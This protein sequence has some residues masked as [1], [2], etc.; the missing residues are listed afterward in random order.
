[1]NPQLIYIP[2][3]SI[4]TLLFILGQIQVS[5]YKHKTKKLT[6]LVDKEIYENVYP[7]FRKKYIEWTGPCNKCGTKTQIIE[8][9]R[10][11][12]ERE[13]DYSP[14][15]DHD[16]VYE[17]KISITKIQRSCPKCGENYC[18]LNPTA[19]RY[20]ITDKEPEHLGKEYTRVIDEDNIDN[21]LYKDLAKNWKNSDHWTNRSKMNEL[22][23]Y[24][25][26][27][28]SYKACRFIG[29]VLLGTGLLLTW[30]YNN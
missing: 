19:E 10:Y 5:I 24:D 2:S 29:F 16:I 26:K 15:S 18:Y 17:N 1:M 22:Y 30:A 27:I 9:R 3:L 20:S 6:K 8:T 4:G 7:I 28:D 14:S 25:H 13:T 12:T 23:D 11:E 21:L